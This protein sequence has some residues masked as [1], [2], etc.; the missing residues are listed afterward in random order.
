MFSVQEKERMENS[1]EEK[2]EM[3]KLLNLCFE[4]QK[5]SVLEKITV[6]LS[7]IQESWDGEI[8]GKVNLDCQS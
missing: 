6:W 2:L 1:V 7:A 5:K 8:R 4:E 3:E